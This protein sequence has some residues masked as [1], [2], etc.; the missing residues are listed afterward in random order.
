M[1]PVGDLVSIGLSMLHAEAI[2]APGARKARHGVPGVGGP[3]QIAGSKP[4]RD[5]DGSSIGTGTGVRGPAEDNAAPRCVTCQARYASAVFSRRLQTVAAPDADTGDD[6]EPRTPLRSVSSAQ[7]GV[8]TADY[9]RAQRAKVASCWVAMNNLRQETE[10]FS[11]DLEQ[12]HF[13]V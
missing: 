11:Q 12:A 1:L 3:P 5:R 7:R 8:G 6:A 10:T 9:E 13:Q 2:Y 4:D